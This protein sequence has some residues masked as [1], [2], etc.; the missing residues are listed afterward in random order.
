MFGQVT[1]LQ[2]LRT[3]GGVAPAGACTEAATTG[4]A[5]RAEYRFFVAGRA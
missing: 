5:Y 3:S 2:R 1:Y 4:V